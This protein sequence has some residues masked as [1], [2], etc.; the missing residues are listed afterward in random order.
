[1]SLDRYIDIRSAALIGP[2]ELE[3]L[4]GDGRDETDDDSS[5]YRHVAIST[6]RQIVKVMLVLIAFMTSRL[7]ALSISR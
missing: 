7:N 3:S 4:A 6:K 2:H 5:S 1:V